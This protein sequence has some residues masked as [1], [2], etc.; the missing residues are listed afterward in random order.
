MLE[1]M[2]YE[3]EGSLEGRAGYRFF[4]TLV[5][6]A[7]EGMP[8]FILKDA[9]GKVLP[10]VFTSSEEAERYRTDETAEKMPLDSLV[11]LAVSEGTGS[12]VIDPGS[13]HP[14][15]MDDALLRG[16]LEIVNAP[17][18]TEAP[19]GSLRFGQAVRI[20]YEI[21]G[22]PVPKQLDLA[23]M[24]FPGLLV[25]RRRETDRKEPAVYDDVKRVIYASVY[26][27]KLYS[28][29]QERIPQILG[30]L[31][32]TAKGNREK[33]RRTAELIQ[34]HISR[35]LAEDTDALEALRENVRAH[36]AS[37]DEV[38]R[39]AFAERLAG[40]LFGLADVRDGMDDNEKDEEPFPMDDEVFENVIYNAA[41]RLEKGTEE[42][43]ADSFLWVLLGGFLR[44][45][46]GRICRIF[47]SSFVPLYRH[48]SEDGSLSDKLGFLF[49]PE[50]YYSVYGGDDLD[51][52][53][54]GTEWYCDRCGE[55]LNEQEG[56]DDHL[57]AWQ[58]LG[59]GYLNLISAD[60]IY[61]NEE[62]H[63]NGIRRFDEED[64]RAAID[65]R[66]K[67]RE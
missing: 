28:G 49:F 40:I 18:V 42:G 11:E 45:E 60:E 2:F 34:K 43:L 5:A 1:E 16:I 65:A 21:S 57:R 46:A 3:A 9:G 13:P 25:I 35:L 32:G 38:Q 24:W 52:R 61:E 41:Y 48:M 66:R 29:D 36:L 20:Y 19:M 55:H 4:R 27:G 51:R 58:C 54:P 17:E 53:F 15:V 33:E 26:H 64:F 23:D 50:E 30:R 59:C 22:E 7:A 37:F 39:E 63:R 67:E 6:C 62:D 31:M 10:Y 14:F 8:V 56:F 44:N 47:D 12:L